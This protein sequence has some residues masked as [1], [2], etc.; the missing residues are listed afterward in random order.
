MIG[1]LPGA[2]PRGLAWIWCSFHMLVKKN[3][4]HP[5]GTQQQP[6]LMGKMFKFKL[7]IAEI[8]P[9]HG[10]P[11]GCADGQG[12][13]SLPRECLRADKCYC[14]GRKHTDQFSYCVIY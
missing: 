5:D 6:G 12:E 7:P 2:L 1:F 9:E 14:W 10:C 4:R 3:V 13:T 8:R 11:E